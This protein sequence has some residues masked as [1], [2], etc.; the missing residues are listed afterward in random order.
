MLPKIIPYNRDPIDD[1]VSGAIEIEVLELYNTTVTIVCAA[2]G[3]EFNIINRSK[4]ALLN[5]QG[6]RE[7]YLDNIHVS[8]CN[9]RLILYI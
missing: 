6:K 1:V 7:I 9:I 8:G 4:E 5:V 2:L 3:D